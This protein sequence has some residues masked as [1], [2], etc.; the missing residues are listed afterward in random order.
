MLYRYV[1]I[2]VVLPRAAISLSWYCTQLATPSLSTR[3]GLAPASTCREVHWGEPSS[4]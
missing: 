1:D 2:Q 3:L 4:L